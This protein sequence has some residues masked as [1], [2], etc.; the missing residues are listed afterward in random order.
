MRGDPEADHWFVR[1]T[2]VD[3]SAIEAA[4]DRVLAG[5]A[6]ACESGSDNA[7]ADE[8]CTLELSAS[9]HCAACAPFALRQ[10]DLLVR[11]Y[12]PRTL[13]VFR[14]T[15]LR[16]IAAYLEA[17]ETVAP[18]PDEPLGALMLGRWGG[19]AAAL[20]SAPAYPFSPSNA[21]YRDLGKRLNALSA[22]GGP[23]IP[24]RRRPTER[25]TTRRRQ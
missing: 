17:P 8:T 11:T 9:P 14:H 23:E 5:L 12:R 3:S 2:S 19:T 25:R 10:L 7:P 13:T 21:F 22:S 16:A 15:S 18:T 6:D 20:A 4:S 1:A 24:D